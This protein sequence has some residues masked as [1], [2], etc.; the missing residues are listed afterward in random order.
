MGGMCLFHKLTIVFHA[1]AGI[2]VLKDAGKDF[3]SKY[4]FLVISYLDLHALRKGA[5]LDDCQVLWE[6]LFIHKQY[7]GSAFLLVAG[8]KSIHHGGGFGSGGR[9][10]QQ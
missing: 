2:G 1:T 6:N 4:Q 8:A 7:V 9:F 3:R 10:I 5:G